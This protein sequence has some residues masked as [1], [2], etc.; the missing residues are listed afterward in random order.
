MKT[1]FISLLLALLSTN[2]FGQCLSGDCENGEGEIRYDD[3]RYTGQF[4]K[5]VK[6]GKGTYYYENG[7]VYSGTFKNDV[8]Q[9]KGTYTF[10]DGEKFTGKFVNDEGDGQ[11]VELWKIKHEGKCAVENEK[12]AAEYEESLNLNMYRL[13]ELVNKKIGSTY[14]VTTT[15]AYK[16]YTN[17]ELDKADQEFTKL[18]ENN[19]NE[20]SILLFRAFTRTFMGRHRKAGA[21]YHKI[22]EKTNNSLIGILYLEG[23]SYFDGDKDS[24]AALAYKKVLAIDSNIYSC[25][26][27][28]GHYYSEIN[29]DKNKALYHYRKAYKL[30]PKNREA[31]VFLIKCLIK[32]NEM[33]EAKRLINELLQSCPDDIINKVGIGNFYYF[34]DKN[35]EAIICYN[36][37]LKIPNLEKKL[38]PDI[39]RQVIYAKAS[40]LRELGKIEESIK[41]FEKLIAMNPNDVDYY[42]CLAF[43]YVVLKNPMQALEI[44]EKGILVD[45]TDKDIYTTKAE[46]YS[47]LNDDDNFYKNMELALKKGLSNYEY[48]VEDEYHLYKKYKTQKRFQDMLAKYKA[49]REEEKDK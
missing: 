24:L 40:S 17:D 12:I 48:I 44:V 14:D 1:L 36:E 47:L 23:S 37:I 38:D 25:L 4:K 32:F 3:G 16:Y 34:E 18:Y 35:D 19:P 20:Y 45:N 27:E 13:K 8:K 42:N 30:Q 22:N 10:F 28:M 46:A 43:D 26:T 31:K 9:G 15:Q 11:Y 39:L 33:A 5:G 21:D 6:S 49:E 2:T 7:D 29:V 41:E